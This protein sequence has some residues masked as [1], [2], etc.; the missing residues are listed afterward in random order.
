MRS[1]P[2]Y[3]VIL[4]VTIANVFASVARASSLANLSVT[5]VESNRCTVQNM[6]VMSSPGG[7]R[8]FRLLIESKDNK[9]EYRS[10]WF[11]YGEPFRLVTYTVESNPVAKGVLME[12]GGS[13]RATEEYTLTLQY[14][15]NVF[16][17][18]PRQTVEFTEYR[19]HLELTSESRVISVRLYDVFTV[20]EKEYEVLFIDA[21]ELRVLVRETGSE[22]TS[23]KWVEKQEETAAP[24]TG[25]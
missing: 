1:F 5:S 19:A 24:H 22:W 3:A 20:G 6:G 7:N 18:A 15:D 12:P 14:A 4:T 13:R 16:L 9:Q 21:Q 8:Q 11:K 10:S 23:F 2:S 17:L 25:E